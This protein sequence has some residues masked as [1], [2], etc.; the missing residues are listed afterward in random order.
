MKRQPVQPELHSIYKVLQYQHQ[1][2]EKLG[3]QPGFNPPIAF[4]L[5]RKVAEKFFSDYYHTRS[6]TDTAPDC[7]AF[8]DFSHASICSYFENRQN[9]RSLVGRNPISGLVIIG[10][11][12]RGP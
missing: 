1:R 5:R 9:K 11:P 8:L 10:G 12:S 7:K 4:A 3:S 2:T 6:I